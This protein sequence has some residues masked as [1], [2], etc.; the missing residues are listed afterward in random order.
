M[1]TRVWLTLLTA[2]LT[3]ASSY[4]GDGQ[5]FSPSVTGAGYGVTSSDLI[6]A[7]ICRPL[8][9]DLSTSRAEVDM[10]CGPRIGHYT[11]L[12]LPEVVSR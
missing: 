1:V 6:M 7:I 5:A 3:L 4:P 12:K 8:R 9:A 2:H 10:F 11:I